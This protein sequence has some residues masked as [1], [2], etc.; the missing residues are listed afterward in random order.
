M[1]SMNQ[2]SSSRRPMGVS[3]VSLIV[4]LNAILVLFAAAT[5][6]FGIGLFGFN[7]PG[8]VRG[9]AI[10]YGLFAALFGI[11]LGYL[12]WGLWSLQR[13]SLYTIVFIEVLNIVEVLAAW[14]QGFLSLIPFILSLI[15]PIVILTY[16]LADRQ[17]RQAFNV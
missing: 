14:A 3:I 13:W 10:W 2:L 15:L 6:I 17:V 7:I 12:S 16:F 8:N 1:N 4:A 5:W 9:F 11:A